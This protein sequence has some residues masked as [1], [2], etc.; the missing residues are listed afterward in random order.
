MTVSKSDRLS[1]F[2]GRATDGTR[3]K[4]DF[5][6]T[7]PIS[8]QSLLNN[9]KFDEVVWEPS[10][11]EGAISKVLINNGYQVISDDLVDRGF[12]NTGLDFLK[13]SERKADSL[14][15][16]PPYALSVPFWEKCEELKIRKYAFLLRV[17]WLEGIKRRIL[18][19]KFP[20]KK[21]YVHAKRIEQSKEGKNIGS[22]ML[23][24]AWFVWEK[25]Y[26][27]KTVEWI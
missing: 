11:G 6:Q 13:A 2:M 12:G 3:V 15:T 17:Q 9:E 21:L 5:Y 26:D 22:P 24:F 7:P 10:C 20:F 8:T 27:T 16:N 18:F 23:A 1:M 4:N 14:I 19:E 25:G